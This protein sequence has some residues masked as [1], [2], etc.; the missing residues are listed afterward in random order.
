M[1]PNGSAAKVDVEVSETTFHAHQTI[2]AAQK[3]G[4]QKK[5]VNAWITRSEKT[6]SETSDLRPF[7]HVDTG[8]FPSLS[9]LFLKPN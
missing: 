6:T 8:E 5:Q 2:P 9:F 4:G 7:I 3:Q 1:V